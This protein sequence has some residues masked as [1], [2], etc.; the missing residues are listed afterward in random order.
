MNEWREIS[1]DSIG[2]FLYA[3]RSLFTVGKRIFPRTIPLDV[4]GECPE[5]MLH[6]RHHRVVQVT[7]RL[8]KLMREFL[9]QLRQLLV[10]NYSWR[11]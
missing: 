2:N 9:L 4:P 1:D 7:T 10:E 8:K 5:K 3:A 11:W 6:S